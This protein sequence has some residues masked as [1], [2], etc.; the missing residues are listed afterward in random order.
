MGVPA[1]TQDLGRDM[2]ALAGQVV[3]TSVVTSESISSSALMGLSRTQLPRFL[4][5]TKIASL[6]SGRSYAS[7][8]DGGSSRRSRPR[9]QH[10]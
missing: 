5:L 1:G 10:S 7:P 4:R 8:L 6:S 9:F 2:R 3:M